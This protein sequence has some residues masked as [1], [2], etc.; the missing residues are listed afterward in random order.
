[1]QKKPFFTTLFAS[2]LILSIVASAQDKGN[3][4][5]QIDKLLPTANEYRTGS[6]KPGP[7][8]W[9]QQAD[10][11]IAVKLDEDKKS[12]SGNETITYHNNSPEILNYVWIQLD[13]NIRE[14]NSLA[15][16]T[17]SKSLSTRMRMSE[18]QRIDKKANGGFNIEQVR[19]SQNENLNY[20][21]VYT[22]MRV[23][24]SKP[25]YPGKKS[26][27]KIK[28]QYNINDR[29]SDNGRSGYHLNKKDSTCVYAI[30]QFFPRMAVYDGVKGWRHK[31][32][33]GSGE[34][35]LP[36]GNYQVRITVPAD[37]IV[38]ATGTLQ[39]E[40]DVLNQYQK[41]Q[42]Q[43]ARN[44][45]D[46][47]VLIVD[48][49]T[50]AA[51][52]KIKKTNR[53]TWVFKAENVR[54]F[55][56]ASSRNFI[57]DAMAVKLKNNNVIAMSFYTAD[58]NPLWEKY[59]TKVLAHAIRIYSKYT[60]EYPY[61]KAVSVLTGRG[62]GMEYPMLAF[63]G[64]KPG[65][66]GTYAEYSKK[67][68]VGVIIHEFGHNI[69]PM[70]VNSD[71]RQWGWMDEG[72]NT[73]VEYLAE[74]EWSRT[75]ASNSGPA[76]T[77]VR[78][79]LMFRYNQIE[80]TPVMT[81]C[82]I[83]PQYF[84]NAY[85]KA[86]AGLNIL[87]ETIMGREIFDFAFKEYARRWKFKHPEPADFFRTMEDASGIDLDWFWRGWFFSTDIVDLSI[88]NVTW[89]TI[90][91]PDQHNVQKNLQHITNIRNRDSI[92]FTA[93]ERDTSLLDKYDKQAKDDSKYKKLL[94]GL[95]SAERKLVENGQNYYQI[96]IHNDKGMV[97]PIILKFEYEDGTNEV[98]RIPVEIWRMNNKEVS[99]VFISEKKI[100]NVILDPFFETADVNTNNNRWT[101]TGNP[102]LIEI[103]RY[104]S[105]SRRYFNF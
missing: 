15:S 98:K 62:G 77:A 65:A 23:D 96:D 10:Y 78:N 102:K 76:Y 39:N 5:R 87:R 41:K 1:M 46:K 54:D 31:Q 53:K 8:Y 49:K 100:K 64:G 90:R 99:K 35:A 3:Q 104:G 75:F 82:D 13:Q 72:M 56:F 89:Y 50:A 34:F 101:I 20:Q 38:G 45:T 12:I 6:G 55:A 74:E 21:I 2:L 88:A 105:Y 91:K 80:P 9:Q 43:K 84:F 81:A 68:L 27:I 44:T 40:N 16:Q 61:P 103:S 85:T 63:N 92:E 29:D 37:H 70:V 28:W 71:E 66:D 93:V 22:M 86:S 58:G 24:L 25:L 42:L 30:A 11:N 19:N 97:M 17:S 33:F 48:E 69:F 26:I 95:S 52:K 4:F 67:G 36:F 18:I 73:F 79:P 14:K 51:K 94:K 7:K 57:W 47:T 83:D 32:F 59:S 60:F